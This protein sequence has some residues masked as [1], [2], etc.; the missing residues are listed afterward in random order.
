MKNKLFLLMLLGMFLISFASALDSL[1][2][3]GTQ[4]KNFT[5][6][7]TCSDA[8]YVTL[9]GILYPDETYHQINTNMTKVSS[10]TFIYNF[11]DTMQ[12]GRYDVTQTSDGCEKT[13]AYHFEVTPS[14]QTGASNIVFFVLLVLL[15]YAVTFV[16]FFGRNLPI[17][18]LGGGVM[19]AFGI[20]L[21]SQGVIVYRDWFTNYLSYVTIGIGFIV[22]AFCIFD[23]LNN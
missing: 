17:S 23:L 7:Q 22:E 16:G 6:I 12:L 1:G 21:I 19:M 10:G 18:M 11:T 5:I 2:D 8:T 4:G 3:A 20:Y 9:D 14:G 15:I 13:F